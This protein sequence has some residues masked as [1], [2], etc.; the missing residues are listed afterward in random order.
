[1][2]RSTRYLFVAVFCSLIA[3]GGCKGE[4]SGNNGAE[5]ATSDA[6]DTADEDVSGE[7]VAEDTAED[8]AQDAAEDTAEDVAEDTSEDVAEDTS[9]TEDAADTTEPQDTED[10]ADTS[11][12]NDGDTCDVAIDV[13][14]GGTFADQTT[15]GLS[16]DYSSSVGADNCPSGSVSGPDIVYVV[17]PSAETTY[18]FTVEPQGSTYDPFIYLKADCSVDACL[19]GTV[20]N[21]PGVQESV[22]YT[23]GVSE[24]VYVIVDGELG[25][26]GAFDLTVE[27]Q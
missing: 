23:V 27:T 17:N 26:S 5:D 6:A 12:G 11:P 7:D 8:A 14:A 22:E 16:D 13:T 21:G 2:K 25:S 15:V 20:L 3:I 10:T 4:D 1:M 24:T 9:D 19:D 18:T